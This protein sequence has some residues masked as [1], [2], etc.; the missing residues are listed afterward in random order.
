VPG[1]SSHHDSLQLFP[2]TAEG[3]SMKDTLAA[4]I[5]LTAMSTTLAAQQHFPTNEDLR[6]LRTISGPQLSPDLKHVVVTVQDSTADGGRTHLWLL[7]TDGGPYRQLTFNQ[8]E[9]SAER[10]P[11]YLPD[12]GTILFISS[13]EGKSKLYR[14]P[15]D[16]GESSAVTL[17]RVPAPNEP[18]S[19][20]GIMSYSISPDGHTIAVVATDPEPASR[21]RDRKDKK[22]VIWVEHNE[23]VHRLYLVDTKT[24]KSHEV[25]TLADID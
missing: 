22:D 2:P 9:T 6:Q 25:P 4:A 17:E 20:V 5:L 8:G 10:N 16:G 19:A 23:T 14:L 11:E 15:L 3:E 21:A 24:W 18:Q 13:R 7:S 12:G 1:G